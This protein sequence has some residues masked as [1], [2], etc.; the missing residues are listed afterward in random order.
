MS[1]VGAKT[2]SSVRATGQAPVPVLVSPASDRAWHQPHATGCPARAGGNAPPGLISPQF[3]AGLAVRE[4]GLERV[5]HLLAI[6]MRGPQA[7]VACRCSLFRSCDHQY[8]PSSMRGH[9]Y[10]PPGPYR[11]GQ[12]R[13]PADRLQDR[14][15][16]PEPEATD[17]A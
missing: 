2:R 15:A 9:H 5:D 7:A 12:Q 13:D 3:D 1:P 6:G 8:L 14:F 11:A 16:P 4:G 17:P 10:G